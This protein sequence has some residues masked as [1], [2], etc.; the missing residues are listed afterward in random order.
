MTRPNDRTRKENEMKTIGKTIRIGIAS[1]ALVAAAG[2]VHA[3]SCHELVAEKSFQCATNDPEFES[4]ALRFDSEELV[5]VEASSP[6]GAVMRC[7]CNST[8][9]ASRPRIEGGRFVTCVDGIDPGVAS[10]ITARVQGERLVQ[11]TFAI[12]G[13]TGGETF[14]FRCTLSD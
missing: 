6:V 13:A 7:F 12:A 14:P 8:G 3:E 11:G 4:F 2:R 5:V 1:L 10:V 9:S